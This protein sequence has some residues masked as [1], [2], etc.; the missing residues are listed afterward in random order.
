[1]LLAINVNNTNIKFGVVDGTT[2]TC[3]LH[4]WSWN[5]TNG[6]CLTSKGHKLRSAKA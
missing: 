1:M 4:G 2:L 3:N 5:L 6:K